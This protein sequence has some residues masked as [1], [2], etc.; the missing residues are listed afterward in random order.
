MF[1]WTCPYCQR[2]TT[3]VSSNYVEFQKTVTIKSEFGEAFVI[4]TDVIV[5]PNALCKKACVTMELHD[6]N[7]ISNTYP[8]SYNIG[9][10]TLYSFKALPKSNSKLYPDYIPKAIRQDYEEACLV[11]NDSPKASATLAR[12]CL[13]GMIRDFWGI[14]KHRLIDEIEA[15]KE[16][17]EPEVWNAIDA[18]RKIGNIGAHME[19][20]INYI[21]DVDPDESRLLVGLIEMLIDEWYVA[22]HTRQEK[23]KAITNLAQ[24][25]GK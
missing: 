5:C 6:A 18:T 14:Q 25:K 24:E 11:L 3:I 1:N 21:V 10:N 8:A 19:K 9:A 17:V 4:Q 16:K 23:L 20:D 22:R 15:I 2:A 12:R 13:Q 7:K